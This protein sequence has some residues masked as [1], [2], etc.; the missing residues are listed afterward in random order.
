MKL[1]VKTSQ[2]VEFMCIE[3]QRSPPSFGTSAVGSQQLWLYDKCG[4]LNNGY[5]YKV[6]AQQ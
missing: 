5:W 4:K 2:N 6:S 1:K 3:G